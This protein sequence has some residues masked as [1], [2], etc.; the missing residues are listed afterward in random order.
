VA[1]TNHNTAKWVQPVVTDQWTP[2][3]IFKNVTFHVHV[4]ALKDCHAHH[5]YCGRFLNG[6]G[7]PYRFEPVAPI[8]L[9]IV[10]QYGEM[11]TGADDGARL[12]QTDQIEL[13]VSFPVRRVAPRLAN[14][15]INWAFPFIAV[16]SATSALSGRQVLGFDKTVGT[17]GIDPPNWD[18]QKRF[19]LSFSAMTHETNGQDKVQQLTK[20]LTIKADPVSPLSR[21]T[22]LW[23]L[24]PRK[25]RKWNLIWTQGIMDL[26]LPGI[27][28]PMNFQQFADGEN[29]GHAFYQALVSSAFQFQD[30]NAIEVFDASE[31]EVHECGGI[32]DDLTGLEL[33]VPH[34][35]RP[36]LSFRCVADMTAGDVRRPYVALSNWR[37]AMAGGPV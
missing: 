7:R 8:T 3:F 32:H 11:R 28:S 37:G 10:A 26:L 21:I 36:V 12:G 19:A 13:L 5:E 35:I 14:S 2:P 29:P 1:D 16:T 34:T 22:R 4:V 15:G 9:L 25:F 18:G 20:V 23:D 31:I 6:P 33:G 17:F 30:V 27:L 24:V